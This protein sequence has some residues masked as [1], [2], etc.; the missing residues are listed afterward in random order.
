MVEEL[1]AF[2]C[3]FIPLGS[4]EGREDCNMAIK[5]FLEMVGLHFL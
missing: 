2:W 4:V 5:L 1:D 3:V